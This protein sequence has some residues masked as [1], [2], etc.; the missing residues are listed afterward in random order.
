MND[1]YSLIIGGISGLLGFLAVLWR[2]NYK[3]RRRSRNNQKSSELQRALPFG[4][5]EEKS[6]EGELVAR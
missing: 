1:F 4:S 3:T 5:S 6:Q 2:M